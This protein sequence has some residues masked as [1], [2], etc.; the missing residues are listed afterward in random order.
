VKRGL[1]IGL[2]GGLATGKSLV[3]KIFMELGAFLIDAD[4]VAREVVRPK[5]HVWHQIVELFGKEVVRD[6]LTLDRGLLARYVFSNQEL[7][8]G[9]NEITHPVIKSVIQNRLRKSSKRISI[10]D[11]PLLVE[12]SMLSLVDRVVVVFCSRETQ[13]DRVVRRDNLT[14]REAEVRIGCQL[15]LPF[16]LKIADFMIRNDGVGIK[17]LREEI[18][19]IWSE[20][21]V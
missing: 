14:R 3:A 12:G 21:I 13:V 4:L 7:R 15:S 19:W 20:F 18:Q 9:L 17:R 8:R 1:V 11:A 5:T 10:I 6:D 16:K 2:T